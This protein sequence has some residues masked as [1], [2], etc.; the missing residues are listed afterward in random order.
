MI[1]CFIGKNKRKQKKILNEEGEG[2]KNRE[3]FLDLS[4]K[5]AYS[6]EKRGE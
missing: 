3:V 2:M 4:K 1:L 6:K 5:E